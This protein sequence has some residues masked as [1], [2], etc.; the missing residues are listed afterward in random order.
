MKEYMLSPEM[1]ELLRNIYLNGSAA[2]SAKA[3]ALLNEGLLKKIDGGLYVLS[4]DGFDLVN[5]IKDD[6]PLWQDTAERVLCVE[7][8]LIND[9]IGTKGLITGCERQVIDIINAHPVF[10]P[11]PFA[12]ETPYYKQII[13]YVCI[14]RGDEVFATR[15][16]NK[17]GEARLHGLLSLGV[18]GH[19]NPTLDGIGDDVLV[20]G[21]HREVSEEVDLR[22]AIGE[23]I[24]RGIINDD[25]N[26]V[27]KVHAGFFYTLETDGEVFVKETEKLEGLWLK[28][29]ELSS[30][31]ENMETWSQIVSEILLKI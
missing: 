20:R 16:L 29:S 9:F 4:S 26:S 11:R 22:G 7:R 23:Y 5:S 28:R 10:L 24:P 18:G 1:T 2:E 8:A 25:T 21:M 13:P 3:V 31:M 30:V 12:E 14:I 15:R 19:I 6:A 17:G 27:G